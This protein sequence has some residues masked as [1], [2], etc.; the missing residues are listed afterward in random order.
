MNHHKIFKLQM[1]AVI[2]IVIAIM[3]MFYFEQEP[4]LFKGKID[5]ITAL[6]IGLVFGGLAIHDGCK[7]IFA[8][9]E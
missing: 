1:K 6:I 2:Y 3:T 9:F 5:D 4:D 8:H 7:S